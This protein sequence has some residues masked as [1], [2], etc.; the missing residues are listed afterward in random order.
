MEVYKKLI[1]TVREN[2][3]I[4]HT[5]NRKDERPFR[6]VIRNLHPTTPISA[7]REAIEETGNT[8][9]GEIINA[10]YG[11][12]KIPT[13]TFFANILPGPNNKAAK[14]IKYINRQVVVIEDPKKRQSVVQCQRCQQ[15]GH[16]KNYCMRPYRC[17]KCA[18]SHKTSECPKTD[19]STPAVCAL[20]QGSHPA[21]YKGCEVYK[22]ILARKRQTQPK[23]L[24]S[25]RTPAKE[26]PEYP[27]LGH[28]I[29]GPGERTYAEIVKTSVENSTQKTL[30]S[31]LITQSEKFDLILQQM[32]ALMSL[33]IKVIDKLTK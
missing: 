9:T 31:L 30:E 17:V 2:G 5:F 24:V 19:R 11:K 13:S 28:N 23:T 25:S 26:I 14:A 12:D 29:R 32:S 1:T 33:M 20:C 6:I 8:V 22:E 27:K 4:G 3:L 10:K 18:Q 15:Y 16:S 21:N 7:I